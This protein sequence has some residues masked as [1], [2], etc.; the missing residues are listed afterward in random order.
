MWGELI[1]HQCI[2][3]TKQAPSHWPNFSETWIAKQNFHW[4][5]KHFQEN[6]FCEVAVILSRM[7]HHNELNVNYLRLHARWSVLAPRP[8]WFLGLDSLCI[9][10]PWLS[11]LHPQIHG[12]KDMNGDEIFNPWNPTISDDSSW[13]ILQNVFIMECLEGWLWTNQ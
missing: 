12:K 8:M 11:L 3:L 1:G 7:R 2:P 9:R 5:E 13:S 4:R 6:V 10:L